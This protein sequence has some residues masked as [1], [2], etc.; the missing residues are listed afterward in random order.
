ME[1]GFTQYCQK[2]TPA[3]TVPLVL[4]KVPAK[5]AK[6]IILRVVPSVWLEDV[7]RNLLLN[8]E[9]GRNLAIARI[10]LC[11]VP[12]NDVHLNCGVNNI[13]FRNG[14]GV[15]EWLQVLVVAVVV[16]SGV[17]LGIEGYFPAV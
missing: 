11:H 10:K 17:G 8:F 1:R 7:I 9:L 14:K 5:S 3:N 4:H 13:V 16:E 15:G 6:L 2:N 12:S